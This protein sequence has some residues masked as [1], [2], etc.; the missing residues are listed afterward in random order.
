M[1]LSV[2]Y[3]T[4]M[5]D[6]ANQINYL[7]YNH[8][9]FNVGNNIVSYNEKSIELTKNE[10]KILKISLEHKGEIVERDTLM[11]YL[12]QTDCYIDDNT[13]SVNVNRLR[14]TLETIGI[15]SFIKTKKGIGYI[16]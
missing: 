6:F 5:Y 14:K 15:S 3:L 16:I 12:W 13:L 2:N 1:I 8:V 11:E 4:L 9:R 10:G 7:E